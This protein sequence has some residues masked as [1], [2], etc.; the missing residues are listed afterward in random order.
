MT[1]KF[2]MGK[3]LYLPL[4][5]MWWPSFSVHFFKSNEAR[6]LQIVLG[7]IINPIQPSFNLHSA[8][9]SLIS[10]SKALFWILDSLYAFCL[11]P[12]LVFVC[13][14]Q[15]AALNETYMYNFHFLVIYYHC[16]IFCLLV[17]NIRII[18]LQIQGLP[19]DAS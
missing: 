1:M 16:I 9:Q 6:F 19:G 17:T 14:V 8:L 18:L 12:Q 15:F 13:I 3:N 4:K 11:K 5:K 10:F 2:D 7:L